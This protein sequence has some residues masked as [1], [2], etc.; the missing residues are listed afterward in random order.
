MS[1][2][3]CTS[4]CW[5]HYFE[6]SAC[7][8]EYQYVKSKYPLIWKVTRPVRIFF[9]KI[10]TIICSACIYHSNN[11]VGFGFRHISGCDEKFGIRI[12]NSEKLVLSPVTSSLWK[13]TENS[14]SSLA[15]D[16]CK[17]LGVCTLRQ[18]ANQRSACLLMHAG[19]ELYRTSLGLSGYTRRKQNQESTE[20]YSK[21]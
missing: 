17:P 12:K 13:K 14:K 21:S 5:S 8:R 18:P 3:M 11:A 4:C 6:C 16:Y 1:T 20:G 2:T 15:Y 9:E 19:K 7:S 10:K